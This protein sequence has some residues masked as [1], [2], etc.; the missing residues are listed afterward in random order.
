[1]T[2]Y[3]SVY[4]MWPFKTGFYPFKMNI[5]AMWK[6]IVDKD[7]AADV[8]HTLQMLLHVWSYDF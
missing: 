6:R 1:M 4:H 3:H 5:S 7:V 8:T 2:T